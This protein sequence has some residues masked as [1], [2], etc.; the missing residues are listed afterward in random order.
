MGELTKTV[1]RTT[2]NSPKKDADM[3]IP[4]ILTPHSGHIDPPTGSWFKERK[5]LTILPFFS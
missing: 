4:V 1:K 3:D 5:G 2:T